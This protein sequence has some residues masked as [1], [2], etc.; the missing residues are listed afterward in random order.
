MAINVNTVYRTVLLLLNKEQRGYMTPT[1]FNSVANQVQLEIFEQYFSDLSQQLK[2]PQTDFD[3]ANKVSIIDGKISA[4][5][6]FGNAVP[7]AASGTVPN[8][9][10][11]PIIDAYGDDDQL[12]QLNTVVYT[13]SLP[14]TVL[15]RLDR[16][17]FYNLQKSDL[18]KSSIYSPTY[19][20]ENKKIFVS[21][22]EIF[23]VLETD[24]EVNY[25]RQP[26]NVTWGYEVGTLGQYVYLANSSIDFELI[27]SE[28]TTVILKILFYAGLIIEDPSVV[29][30]ASAQIQ[31]EEINSKS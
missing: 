11:L 6:T 4:F 28:Q 22:P 1:E 13:K 27:I 31:Q 17:D 24:I 25:V 19:L 8:H 14:Y 21:P 12:Y 30:I 7:V 26:R 9:F 20:Y 18:T 16:T 15:Q 10:T 3:Y 2:A 5:K 23:D 29:Q